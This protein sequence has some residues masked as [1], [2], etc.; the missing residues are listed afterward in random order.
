M[1]EQTIGSIMI[2]AGNFAPSEWAF[3]D[4]QLLPINDYQALFS[5]VGTFY[6]GDGRTTFALPDLRGKAPIHSGNG[7]PGPGLSSRPLG[8]FGGEELHYLN[9]PEMPGHNHTAIATATGSTGVTPINAA[10]TLHASNTGSSNDPQ[11]KYLANVPNIGPNKVK[12]Y[13][14]TADIQMNANSVTIQGN[15]DL[16]NLPAPTVTLYPNG[17]SYGHN[18]MQPYLAINYIIALTGVYPSRS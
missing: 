6:G 1:G 5:I 10:A 4:G 16:S 15:V 18:N 2:F 11:G 17:N 9:I 13:G 8:Q 3:C 12:S 14:S 7:S